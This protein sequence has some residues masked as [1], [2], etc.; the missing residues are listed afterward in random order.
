M[1]LDPTTPSIK[2]RLLQSLEERFWSINT[3]NG[4]LTNVMSVS[5]GIVHPANLQV[6]PAVMILPALDDPEEGAYSI[7]R[8]QFGVNLKCWVRPHTNLS[9]ELE[10]LI[11][12]VQ[13][14]MKLDERWSVEGFEQGLAVKT[15]EG[16]TTYVYLESLEIEAGAE[17]SYIIHYRTDARDPRVIMG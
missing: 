17:I 2:K 1:A 5:R 10:D 3:R 15:V 7:H 9:N 11:A 14:F 6:F 13:R 4:Y 12:D 8:R 16:A